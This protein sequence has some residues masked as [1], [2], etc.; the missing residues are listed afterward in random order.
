MT[1]LTGAS[2]LGIGPAAASP[3]INPDVAPA[4]ST[5][6]SSPASMP[7]ADA[8][9]AGYNWIT[10]VNKPP[11]RSTTGPVADPSTTPP[12]DPPTTGS[13]TDTP[14]GAVAV[15]AQSGTGRRIVYDISAQRV[16][17]VDGHGDVARTYLVSGSRN[18]SL[19][20]P[21]AY[22]VTSKSRHAVSYNSKETMNYMVRF[23]AGRSSPIGF[24]DIPARQDGSLV[25]SRSDLGT[26]QS[27]G[28]I[29]QWISD[30]TALWEFANVG[31]RVVV[32]A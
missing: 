3:P 6:P 31:T 2:A 14:T 24:H 12:T 21:G 9:A 29:R 4:A 17:L 15:P 20:K 32:T 26:P 16:W 13:E 7:P 22:A 23:A 30:A 19:L 8:G 5:A 1:V 25:E 28:C 10:V 18:P 11:H 27:A